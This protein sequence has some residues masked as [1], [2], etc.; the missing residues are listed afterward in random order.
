MELLKIQ[1]SVEPRAL[2]FFIKEGK[3]EEFKTEFNKVFGDSFR[4]MT[5]DEV[6]SE[7]I[8]GFGKPHSKTADFIGNFFAVAIGETT[9]DYKRGDFEFVG[10]HAGLT[11]EEMTVPFIAIETEKRKRR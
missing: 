6:F 9:I 2:S 5:K 7:N 11:E 8:L 1:P 3:T 10:V 4:L